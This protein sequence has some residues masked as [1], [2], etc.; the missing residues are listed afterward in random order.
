MSLIK[1][2]ITTSPVGDLYFYF[3]PCSVAQKPK[4]N[5]M[6]ILVMSLDL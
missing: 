6:E 3:Y 4:I 5:T 2:I 1:P